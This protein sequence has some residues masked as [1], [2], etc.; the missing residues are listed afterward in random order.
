MQPGPMPRRGSS[1]K[2]DKLGRVSVDSEGF[3][4]FYE[5]MR[6]SEAQMRKWG[7]EEIEKG[8][9]DL[10]LGH[11]CEKFNESQVDGSL[12]VDLDEAVLRDL[13]LT[14]FEA[15]KLRKFVFGW[16]PDFLR[17]AVYEQKY[18]KTSK[19]PSYWSTKIVADIIGNELGLQDF[20]KFCA[21]NQVNGDLLRDLVVDEE[22]LDALLTGKG[23]KLNA[24]KLKNFVLDGWRPPKKKEGHYESVGSEE[25]NK[26]SESGYEPLSPATPKS[27][28]FSDVYEEPVSPSAATSATK[29]TGKKSSGP[30]S[31]V[32][33]S[34]DTDSQRKSSRE[35]AKLVG[36]TSVGVNSLTKKYETKSSRVDAPRPF[37]KKVSMGNSPSTGANL[38]TM[39]DAPFIANMKKKFNDK[40]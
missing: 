18:S 29:F 35:H 1:L 17:D 21:G 4:K 28:E 33:I 19:N 30:S 7:P 2:G 13:G 25:S 9:Q 20:A 38:R 11:H 26:K 16:R 39:S 36:A 24:V 40:Q 31:P 6:A 5:S 14:A 23:S 37:T 8:L 27:M 34:S 32:R 3:R 15:R 22:L 12:L 10:Q